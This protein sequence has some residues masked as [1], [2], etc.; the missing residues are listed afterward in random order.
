M[1]TANGDRNL[2]FG[3][4][5]LQMDF[6]SG[7]ALLKAMQSWVVEKSKRLGQI[8]VEQDAL[9]A[10]RC[11]LLESLVDEHVQQHGG[12]VE[13]S[14]AA[15]GPVVS[16]HPALEQNTASI[17]QADQSAAPMEGYVQTLKQIADSDV[18]ASLIRLSAADPNATKRQAVGAA[19]KV[20]MRFRILRPHAEG[21]LGK[22][23]VARDEELHREVALKEIQERHADDYES[24]ARFL[25]EAEITGAL[26][27][28]GVVP[29][30]GLGAYADG[31]PFYAMRFIKGDTLRHAIDHFY[32]ADAA[33]R[34]ANERVLELRK[35]LGRFVDVCDA[36]A[37]AHSRGI[38]HRDLKPDNIMLGKYG[39]TLVVDW[40]LAKPVGAPA[41]VNDK[42]ESLFQPSSGEGSGATQMGSAIGTPQYMP[43]EQAAGRLDELGPASDVYSLGATLFCVLTGKSP[44][45]DPTVGAVLQKVQRGEFPPPRQV[46]PK[47]PPALNAVCLKAMALRPEDRYPTAPALV[48]DIE[49]WLAD[50][51]VSAWREP[52]RVR[53]GR[54]ARRN[55]TLVAATVAG[56]LVAI[57]A[58]GA[59]VLWYQQEQAARAAEHAVRVSATAS[60]VSAALDDA[61]TLEKQAATVTNDPA[62][63]RE[64]LAEALSAVKRAE[65]LLNSGEG[66]DDMRARVNAS[67]DELEA[68]DKDRRLIAQ[69]E[70]VRLQSAIAGKD[71]VFDYAGEA[72][73]YAAAFEKD[74]GFSSLGTKEAAER[75]S[76]REIRE[77]L[78]AALADWSN[79][80]PNKEDKQRLRDILKAAD[81]DPTTFR[82]RWNAA[83]ERKDLN[84]Q[85]HL[86]F[87][88][89]VAD[90]P[91]VRVVL[92]GSQLTKIDAADAVRFLKE[93]NERRPGDFWILFRLGHA[94][95]L[96]TPPQTDDAI[97][98]FTAALALRPGSSTAH[99]AL[100]NEFWVKHQFDDAIVEYHDAA[101]LKPDNAWAYNGLGMVLHDQGKRDEATAEFKK[102]IDL[103]AKIPQPHHNLGIVLHDQ[104]KLDEAA[105]EYRE[106][107]AIDPKYLLAHNGLGGVLRDQGKRD[108]AAAEYR[109]VIELD[110]KYT[111]AY[112][113]LG[114][115]LYDEGKRDE[116]TAQYRKAIELNP[117][118]AL[119]HFNL[120]GVLNVQGKRDEAIV[121]YR[122]AI[123]LD[124]KFALWHASLGNILYDGGKRD[125]AAAEYRKAFELDPNLAQ[126]HNGLGNSLRDRGKLE[127]AVAEYRKA[128]ELDPKYAVPHTNLGGVL[129]D[130]GKLEEAVAE[131]R[132][133]IALDPSYVFG[134]TGLG[135]V[136]YDQHKLAEAA[137]EYRKAVELNP[138]LAIAHNGLGKILRDQG[139]REEA[140]AEFR[141]AIELDP[142]LAAA[143]NKFGSTLYNQGKVDEAFAQYR[144]A[145]ELDPK[146]AAAHSNLGMVLFDRGK[147]DEAA[148]EYRKTI[149]LDPS[150]PQGHNGLGNILRDQGKRE[151][152]AAEFHKAIELDPKFAAAHNGLANVLYDQGLREE[153]IT[154]YRKAIDFFP[155]F[156]AAHNNLGNVLREQGKLEDA[157]A[158]FR[159]AI[160]LDPKPANTHNGFGNVLRDQRKF[161]EAAAEFRKAIELDPKS[162][163][164]HYNLGL[165]LHN[166]GKREEATAEYRKAIEL[167]PQSPNAHNG[168]GAVLYDQG[169]QEEAAAEYRA[170]VE[171]NLKYANP[172][173]GLGNILCDQGKREAATVEYRKAIELDSKYAQAHVALGI[174]LFQLGRFAEAQQAIQRGLKLLQAEDTLHKVASEQLQRCE[175]MLTLD[176]KLTAVL[177]GEA[178]PADAAEQVSLA[179]LCSLKNLHAAAARFYADAFAAKPALAEDMQAANRYNAACAA[180]RAA[181]GDGKGANKLD[182]KERARLRHEALDWLRADLVYAHKQ[183]ESEDPKSRAAEKQTL[184]HWQED[185]DL[186]SVRDA[187]TQEKLPEVER[188]DWKK[189]WTDVEE[190]VKKSGDSGKK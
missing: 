109:K 103:N 154:E 39:E 189:L 85:R 167:D 37:Y 130:Q 18:Q 155:K 7:D 190:L 112:N 180:V 75:V 8:L 74:M 184:R 32:K 73:Q 94:C 118:Y 44:F 142:E 12:E 57:L 80:T 84:A 104:R 125:E 30:Y 146:F 93:A 21:G 27:H 35:L 69:L 164:P 185:T 19:S 17:G 45:T 166:Q 160:E 176:K 172:H 23:S 177:K 31:R 113:G 175:Q 83:I 48:H 119:V 116:A 111:A 150:I 182:D 55:H 108:E 96:S 92:L 61:A 87:S 95:R 148:D 28:P 132:K 115:I 183:L 165:V 121:E 153:A 169:K 129:R 1:A 79:V 151:A 88:S 105:A 149:E 98:Y 63:W 138:K 181:A 134:H 101:R 65:G 144:N 128:V 89:E 52:W 78:L 71:S 50:E 77:E 158:E 60:G 24:R 163:L 179:A 14:L 137:A 26:E 20:G 120:G 123:E 143:F 67:R 40:G 58:G 168:L 64:S 46:N 81:P 70:D 3:I 139:E 42:M 38:L 91:T 170:A 25:I 11:A 133:T 90:Q 157:A 156:A 2:L 29:V 159:K 97:R 54:W 15:V 49:K 16:V 173:Y 4:L 117:S 135:L 68:A 82:N 107:I 13:K 178:K 110:P 99:I 140:A 33:G 51:P 136:L 161:D 59:G 22:V 34:P 9:S 36:I 47:V 174:A 66:T 114:N 41:E 162:V 100:G 6:I 188:T 126:A 86:A 127:E 124:P 152:A 102:A 76:S 147:R 56:L 171:L 53:A 145:V 122:K 131:Y 186:A 141:Q 106:A 187:A 72:A 62:R 5:A 10:D 43:P